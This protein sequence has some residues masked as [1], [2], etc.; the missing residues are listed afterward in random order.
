MKVEKVLRAISHTKDA[1]K[2]YSGKGFY[3][4]YHSLDLR[5]KLYKGQRD[6][7]MRLSKVGFDFKDKTVLDMGCNVGGM[8][9]E[10]APVIRYG[11]GMD[12]NY[13][14]V[15][16]ANLIR[17]YNGTHNINF[18][19]FNLNTQDLS[20]IMDFVLLDKIDIC[21]FLSMIKWVDRWVEIIEFSKS[22]SDNLLIELNG[23]DQDAQEK[24]IRGIYSN[25]T[26]VYNKSLDDPG[27]HNRR[28]L[29]CNG[30]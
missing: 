4:G 26:L 8:L 1:K 21:F 12:Y 23:S 29:L 14:C 13:D 6:N 11:V 7:S 15:N 9:H 20:E 25:V 10:L 17:D 3:A 24:I 22:I 16:A 30:L 2:S 18:Y 5:G 28:L 27:Q 19:K